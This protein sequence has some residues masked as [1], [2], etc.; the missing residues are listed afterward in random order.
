LLPDPDPAPIFCPIVSADDHLL[1]PPDLFVDRVPSRYR[2]TV[3]YVEYDSE[4]VPYWI[5]AGAR[6]GITHVNGAAGR[7]ISE[8]SY[9]ATKYEEFRRGVWDSK[10]RLADLDHMGVYASVCFPSTVFGF[11]GTRLS[12]LDDPDAGLEAVRAYNRWHLDEWCGPAPERYIP[13]QI[14]WLADPDVAAKEIRRN[15][16]AGFKCVS[17]SENPENL[18][19]AGLHS[20]EWDVFFL[21]CEET[22]TVVNLHVGSSGSVTQ[23]SRDSPAEVSMSLFPLN[24]MAALADWLYSRIP[25]RF[26]ELRIV[27]SEAGVGWVPMMIDK[28]RRAY[29]LLDASQVWTRDDPEPAEVIRR[30]FRFTSIEDPSI[31]RSLDLVGEDNVMAES[32]YPHEDSTW[33]DTQQVLRA[34]L[35][36]LGDTQVRKVC[37]SNACRLYRHAAPPSTMLE[38]SELGAGRTPSL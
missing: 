10:A 36:S 11:A 17:F 23:P 24:G 15:A 16:A 20:R 21:A 30:S 25:L 5:I 29:R 32:D 14:P 34:Q 33:P 35:S 28:I 1:E 27:L 6:I 13:C 3:P 4:G 22:G 2:D 8:I 38:P 12:K 18:G 31:W 7:P 9:Q 19:F 37:Y 26:P